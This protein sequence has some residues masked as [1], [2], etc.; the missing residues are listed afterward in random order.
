MK[1]DL[2]FLLVLGIVIGYVFMLYKIEK[3]ESMADVGNLDQ[4]KEAV[5]QVYMADVEAI[6][7]LSNVATQLQAGGLTVPGDL[8]TK[9]KLNVNSNIT[10]NSGDFHIPI[11]AQSNADSHIQ[12]K[13]KNDDNKNVYLVNRDSHF[14]VNIHGVGDMLGVN[15]DGHVWTR[16]TGDHTLNLTADGNNPYIS[17]GKNGSWEKKTIYMQNVDAHTENPTFRVGIHGVGSL[18][19][20]NKNK[21]L[22][23]SGPLTIGGWTI[24]DN[25]GRLEFLRDGD[26]KY[27]FDPSGDMMQFKFFNF[28]S[29][30]YGGCNNGRRE[31]RLAPRSTGGDGVFGNVYAPIKLC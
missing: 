22:T 8:T 11:N 31:A 17:L 9:G 26:R 28:G 10:A 12:L 4:I 3:V 21:G 23:F 27:S 15:K 14:R 16:H 24:S 5:K 19:D 25:N 29:F 20:L 30:N 2:V 13:T 7:N 6:R 1:T 18:M